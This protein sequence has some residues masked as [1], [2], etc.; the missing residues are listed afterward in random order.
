[1]CTYTGGQEIIFRARNG[2]FC[3]GDLCPTKCDWEG[4]G[5]NC[6]NEIGIL[7]VHLNVIILRA[8]RL[9]VTYSHQANSDCGWRGDDMDGRTCR[10][11]PGR[12]FI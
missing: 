4:P 8:A 12:Y 9:V 11:A 6:T 7:A 1:V 5:G 3:C 10:N 2:R